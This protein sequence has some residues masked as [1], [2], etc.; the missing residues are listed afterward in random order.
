MGVQRTP[1]DGLGWHKEEEPWHSN[2]QRNQCIY[3]LIYIYC[4]CFRY[5][6]IYVFIK[7]CITTAH[8]QVWPAW[9][10]C[11]KD[12]DECNRWPINWRIMHSQSPLGFAS[13]FPE[14]MLLPTVITFPDALD[15][16]QLL[17]PIA[18]GAECKTNPLSKEGALEPW[19]CDL[20]AENATWKTKIM[21]KH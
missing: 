11:L 10:P 6:Y 3:I 15:S 18:V 4:Y 21:N 12:L 17:S 20:S 16:L 14:M 19:N 9:S 8:W 7:K 2:C 1:W 5:I 13:C